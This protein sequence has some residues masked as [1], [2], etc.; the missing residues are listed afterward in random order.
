[1]STPSGYDKS[2]DKIIAKFFSKTEK[3]YINVV[4]YSYNGG[5]AKIRL[6]PATKNTNPEADPKKQWIQSKGISGITK[7]EAKELV[8]ALNSAIKALGE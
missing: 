1:M 6:V 4:V 8:V 5:D 2:K 7:E 3:R